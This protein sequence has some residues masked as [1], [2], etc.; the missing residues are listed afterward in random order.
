MFQL[1]KW[2]ETSPTTSGQKQKKTL[3]TPLTKLLKNS[4]WRVERAGFDTAHVDLKLKKLS[5]IGSVSIGAHACAY[6]GVEV[7]LRF[8][9]FSSSSIQ[10][11]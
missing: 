6:V 3:S 1:T 7:S 5:K 10:T 8:L 4:K 11:F 2:T 9:G